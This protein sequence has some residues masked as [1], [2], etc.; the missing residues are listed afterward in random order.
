M[1]VRG[2][3][4]MPVEFTGSLKERVRFVV[5]LSSRLRPL[6]CPPARLWPLLSVWR[7]YWSILMCRKYVDSLVHFEVLS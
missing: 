1:V 5:L 2:G 4:P 3:S 7:L 6:S